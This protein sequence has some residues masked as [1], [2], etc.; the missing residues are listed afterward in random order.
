MISIRQSSNGS[1]VR[2]NKSFLILLLASMFMALS[3]VVSKYVLTYM[4]FW[5]LF[6]IGGLCMSIAF[7]L[8]SLRKKI[9]KQLITLKKRKT[10]F[11]IIFINESLAPVAIVLSLLAIEKGPV[12]LV[13]TIT[14]SRP[15]F[16]V[17]L[18]LFLSRFAP[19]FLDWEP[20]RGLLLLRLIATAM[21]VSGI[22]I[23]HLL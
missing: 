12:S 17:M 16:V 18:A 22:I 20:G 1:F 8:V 3:D 10:A 9:L 15:I 7:L 2:F 13:S 19:R 6:W 5:N 11:F 21:I 14:S 4:S 23:I